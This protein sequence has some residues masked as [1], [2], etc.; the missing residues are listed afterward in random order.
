MCLHAIINSFLYPDFLLFAFVFH[1]AVGYTL[2]VEA[3][4]EMKGP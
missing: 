2:V 1:G 3:Y 4:L